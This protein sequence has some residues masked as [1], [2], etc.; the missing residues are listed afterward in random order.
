M[1]IVQFNHVRVPVTKYGGAERVVVWLSQGLVELGHQVTLLAPKGSRVEG[2]RVVADY[3]GSR[4]AAGELR[5]HDCQASARLVFYAVFAA[6]L[7]GTP[8]E[9]FLPATIDI[10]MH[11]LLAA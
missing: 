9:P 1:H 3:L 2:V 11:G 4:V 5:P 7:S 10:V 6:H 8:A